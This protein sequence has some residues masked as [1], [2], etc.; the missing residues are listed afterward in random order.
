LSSR[1]RLFAEVEAD[2]ETNDPYDH[3]AE[4]DEVEFTD[5]CSKALPLVRV[6]VEEEE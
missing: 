6:E 4:S 1:T 5:V 3:E 2:Q